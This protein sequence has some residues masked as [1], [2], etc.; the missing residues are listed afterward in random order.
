[1]QIRRSAGRGDALPSGLPQPRFDSLD[2]YRSRWV[3]GL[4]D[5]HILARRR[6]MTAQAEERLPM[7]AV[8]GFDEFA[9]HS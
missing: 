6:A 7:A 9:Q 1:M 5:G 3:G 8:S 4:A 2:F